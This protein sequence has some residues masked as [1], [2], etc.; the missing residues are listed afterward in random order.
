MNNPKYKIILS[1]ILNPLSDTQADYFE[2]GALVLENINQRYK[3]A[4][5]GEASKI[6]DQY[7]N[8]AELIDLK[9]KIVLPSFFDMH[10]HWVQDDVSAMPKDSLLSWLTNY[11]WPSEAKFK[12]KEYTLKKVIA[13]TQKLLSVGTLGG[14]CFASIHPHTVEYALDS[15]IGDFIVGNVLM[16]ENSPDYLVQ[17]ENEALEI[18]KYLSEKYTDRYALTPRFALTATPL[19]MKETSKIANNNN[20]F[21]QT[22]LSETTF[23]ISKTLEH[24]R[25][26]PG[27]EDVIS[28]TEIYERCS[29]LGDKTIVGHG[30]HLS[31]EE[32]KILKNTDTAI[33][34]CPSSN[35]PISELGL[36]SGLFDFLKAEKFG[37]RW[38]LATDIGG[39]PFL[40]M[41]DVMESFVKQN[42]GNSN[43]TY[44]KAL[45]R[46]TLAGAQILQ[47]DDNTGNL[48]PGKWA[49]FIC[50]N[51]PKQEFNNIEDLITS[52]INDNSKREKY[53]NL[54][55]STYY[56]GI[57]V[58]SA[59]R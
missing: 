56:H 24:I 52:I 6:L 4:E 16:T 55:E 30:I 42:K 44:I 46:S 11:T 15:F 25:S 22:H 41:F 28:Y 34:H 12:S 48:L 31:D 32:W 8:D 37:V 47:V 39:G 7:K 33:A 36:G 9:D 2:H 43:A 51:K 58:F 1:S 17:S 59:K 57:E 23:E 27:Y 54:I 40:S 45:F 20:S 29:Q 49:N 10:F 14:A 3:V 19:L 35:A 13:F 21:I 5:L 53:L 38:A 26:Y 50:I 18:V